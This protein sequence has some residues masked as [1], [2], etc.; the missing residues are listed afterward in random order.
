MLSA[1]GLCL[2]GCP[3][4]SGGN[5]AGQPANDAGP[6]SNDAGP[7]ADAGPADAGFD[8]GTPA[9]AGVDAGHDAGAPDS[10]TDAGTSDAGADAGPGDAGGSGDGGADAGACG[11]L[12]E[13]CCAS[14]AGPACSADLACQDSVC[15]SLWAQWTVPGDEP[16]SGQYTDNSD[17]TVTDS[18]TGLIW[19]KSLSGTYSWADA[20]TYCQGQTL[21]QLSSGWRLPTVNELISIVDFGVY[22][23]AINTSVFPSTPGGNFWTSTPSPVPSSAYEISFIDGSGMAFSGTTGKDNVRCVHSPP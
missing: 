13:V 18:T 11:G 15:A 23:P 10:G 6:V 9:D 5:D 21:H 14:D 2:A 17:G 3:A 19:Q 16:A 22:N 1:I 8:A 20:Q 4:P 12:G 7:G